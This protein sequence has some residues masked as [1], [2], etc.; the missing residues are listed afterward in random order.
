VRAIRALAALSSTV[1][2]AGCAALSGFLGGGAPT[3]VLSASPTDGPSPLAVRFDASRSEDDARIVEYAWDLGDG[4]V[5]A[6]SAASLVDHTYTRS[7]IF[8]ARLTVTDDDGNAGAGSVTITVENRPPVASFLLSSDAPVVG[9]RVGLDASGSFD[10]DGD[11]VGFTWE[12]GDGE[13][14][15][16]MRVS[17]AYTEV[18]VY[19]I[20][21]TV[22]DNGGETAS[23]AHAVTVHLGGSG[24]CSGGLPISL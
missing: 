24:G 11:L 6:S 22:E 1:L 16:G 7:G 9:D 8:V 18:G 4:T 23:L 3:V 13:S 2:L 19:T 5:E 12:F 14:V 20:R 21:L 10:V 17:H 15:R